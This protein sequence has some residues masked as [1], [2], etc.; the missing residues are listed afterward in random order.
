MVSCVLTLNKEGGNTSCQVQY[1]HKTLG[2]LLLPHSLPPMVR[3]LFVKIAGYKNSR[4]CGGILYRKDWFD[5]AKYG[6]FSDTRK[7]FEEN[8]QSKKKIPSRERNSIYDFCSLTGLICCVATYAGY[9]L[10]S[11]AKLRLKLRVNQDIFSQFNDL[12]IYHLHS[13]QDGE[14]VFFSVPC[15]IVEV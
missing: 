7:H 15:G 1:L 6:R 13:I 5:A 12:T 8:F 10:S 3:L 9:L 2:A 4:L 14:P 11:A